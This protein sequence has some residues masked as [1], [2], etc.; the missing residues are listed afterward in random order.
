[1]QWY[2]ADYAPGTPSTNDSYCSTD[3]RFCL[4][5]GAIWAY[6]HENTMWETVTTENENGPKIIINDTRNLF[7]TAISILVIS[8][9][10]SFRVL[11]DKI[12]SEYSIWKIY[13][14]FSIRNGRPRKPALCQLYRH[15]F[16]PC[17]WA[18]K[19]KHLSIACFYRNICAKNHQDR[20]VNDRVVAS[21]A[22]ELFRETQC[23]V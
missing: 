16:V 7:L 8:N 13:L 23:K 9:H 11:F 5:H 14:Y 15:T 22:C 6:D 19:I 17:K 20:S 21:H 4:G 18:R 10:D 1:M 2:I 12:A 3:D